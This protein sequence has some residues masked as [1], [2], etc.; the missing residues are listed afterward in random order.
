[1][2]EFITPQTLDQ[3]LE[4]M[5]NP[6]AKAL[7]GG[8]DLMIAL[9]K[10]GRAGESLPSLIVDLCR[11]P[12]L[13]AYRP[14]ADE[15]YLGA[16]LTFGFLE[17]D[18]VTKAVFPLLARAAATVGSVQVRQT[19]T[20]GGNVAN[21]SPAADGMSALCALGARAEIASRSGVRFCPIG[22]LITAPGKNTL[23]PNE[24]IT[25]FALDKPAAKTGQV[26]AKVGR[27]QA[28][29]IARLNV[30]VCLDDKLADPRVVLGACFPTPRRLGDVEQLIKNGGPGE[31]LWKDA[32]EKAGGHF[33]DVC[34][35]R[36]SA[37]Y[38][39]PAIA[40]MMSRAL[41]DAWQALGG[42]A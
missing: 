4:A 17:N 30:A 34:G 16:G 9:R 23:L 8:T 19:A 22:E 39:V 20:I 28:V 33:V 25:G 41:A 32:G 35:W 10:A 29:S 36:S 38:K 24:I 14:E 7:A 11:V 31:A 1:M 15:P 21:A 13:Q 40:R 42:V 18:P 12:E 2:S 6:G 26:F 37:T 5:E 27:R 3:A